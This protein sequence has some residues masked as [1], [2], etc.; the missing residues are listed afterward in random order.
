MHL[1]V[2]L[3][4][5]LPKHAPAGDYRGEAVVSVAGADPV[6][7]PIQLSVADWDVPDPKDYRTYVGVYQ[8]PTTLALKY[9]VPE[10][11][12]EHWRLMD[13]SFALLG[14]AGNK[15]VN[16]T[17]VE[18]TQFGNEEGMIYW[19][20]QADGSYTYDF[21]V[22]DRLID[23][24][25]KHFRS[26]D[27]VVLHVWHSGGWDT[28]KADQENTVTVVDAKTGQRSTCK[29]P[30]SGLKRARD[31]GGRCWRPSR[32]G[33]PSAVWRRRCV[34]GFS[35][36]ALRRRRC[37]R[38]STRSCPA[39]PA[40]CAAATAARGARSR[41]R[42]PAAATRYCTSSATGSACRIPTSPCR[43]TGSRRGWPGA[44]YDRISGHESV[45]AAELVPR[46]GGDR[47][48]EADAGY[49]PRLPGFPGRAF[50]PR[51][52]VRRRG[53]RAEHLQPLAAL[54]LRTAQ[55]RA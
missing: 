38:H 2:L 30:G 53:Q 40:G 47:A 51:C 48:H 28:R 44:D 55:S 3:R 4:V 52:R 25:L 35:P 24:A 21:T 6:R 43:R 50:D 23:L 49:R 45:V 15:L 34:W 11:S 46:H 16:V 5:S 41:T 33:W 17:V 29:C 37:S 10:W 54:E 1:P 27:F 42:C 8:S 7:V 12:E 9:N 19:I 32:N 22:F 31:S 36:T 14:R 26:L 20:R 18:R 13:K 39:V